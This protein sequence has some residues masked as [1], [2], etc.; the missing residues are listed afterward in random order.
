MVST[1]HGPGITDVAAAR[2][3]P[4]SPVVLTQSPGQAVPR[5]MCV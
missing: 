2:A 1:S 5:S 3:H 4:S